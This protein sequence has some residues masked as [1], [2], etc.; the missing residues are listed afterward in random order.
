MMTD[1][2]AGYLVILDG[3]I[4]EDDAEALIKAIKMFKGVIKVEP[5]TED[6][7]LQLAI[8]RAKNELEIKLWSVLR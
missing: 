8:A 2:H 4:R 7:Q 6:I 5:V 1:R 3:P